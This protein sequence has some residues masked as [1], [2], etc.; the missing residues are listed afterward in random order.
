MLV[1]A[2]YLGLGAAC[3][4]RGLFRPVRA[5]AKSGLIH[6]CE[7]PNQFGV[8]DPSITIDVNAGDKLYAAA[9]GKIVS[10]GEDYLHI[11]VMNERVI[12]MYHGVK[13]LVQVGQYV[14]LGQA[15]GDSQG[16]VYFS[17]TAQTD[18]ARVLV[19]PSAWLAERGV[20]VLLKDHSDGTLWCAQGRDIRVP[21]EPVCDLSLPEPSDFALLPIRIEKS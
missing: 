18:T 4:V 9:S 21:A 16:R 7:G 8:C 3:L 17:V 1:P 5:L 15:V 12:L 14:G 10:V 2:L 13:P 6:R 11:L 19:S 20:K